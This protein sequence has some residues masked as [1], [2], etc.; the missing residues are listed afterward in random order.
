MENTNP[1]QGQE[2]HQRALKTASSSRLAL[3]GRRAERGGRD[4][5][6][7]EER[8]CVW[9]ESRPAGS[10][11]GS[12]K[13][14]LCK[15]KKTKNAALFSLA[16][17]R[18]VTS[19]FF[20]FSS[21]LFSLIAIHLDSCARELAT[22]LVLSWDRLIKSVGVKL[23]SAAT[24]C[25]Q[26]SSVG[27]LLCT[28]TLLWMM[29]FP[30]W[31]LECYITLY[32]KNKWE[33]KHSIHPPRVS[34]LVPSQAGPYRKT[35]VTSFCF[36]YYFLDILPV[37][38][39]FS[40]PCGCPDEFPRHWSASCVCKSSSRRQFVGLIPVSPR[41]FCPCVYGFLPVFTELLV[42]ASLLCLVSFLA[43]I[44]DFEFHG[45]QLALLKAHL[46]VKATCVVLWLTFHFPLN[47]KSDLLCLYLQTHLRT[48]LSTGCWPLTGFSG[49][50]NKEL[51]LTFRFFSG[52]LWAS[53][54]LGWQHNVDVYWI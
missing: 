30:R 42:Y 54:Y 22:E 41:V 32:R 14:L 21:C 44:L 39:L 3:F 26:H 20:S 51:L 28:Q 11:D 1:D 36:T 4:G 23:R 31:C 2:T 45:V 33:N 16:D 27:V 25:I 50:L 38:L 52:Y 40:L 13:A 9:F 18:W 12:M 29:C 46:W 5:E 37:F 19:H 47:K 24:A 7:G 49:N 17:R 35:T 8:W 43:F 34:D 53:Q 10:D 48:L 15:Q 6:E